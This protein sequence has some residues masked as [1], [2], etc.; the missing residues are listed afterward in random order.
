M[1]N[2]EKRIFHLKKIFFNLIIVNFKICY[3][4]KATKKWKAKI[5]IQ[6][7]WDLGMTQNLLQIHNSVEKFTLF[8]ININSFETQKLLIILFRLKKIQIK[9]AFRNGCTKKIF[10]DY[11][12]KYFNGHYGSTINSQN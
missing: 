2:F 9:F 8:F 6:S 7:N 4:N 11:F 5:N 1:R 10:I 12:Y 3:G